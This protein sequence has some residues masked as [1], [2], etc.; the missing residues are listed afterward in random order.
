MSN[1][2]SGGGAGG[3]RKKG[4]AAAAPEHHGMTRPSWSWQLQ[5]GKSAAV[6]AAG[7]DPPFGSYIGVEGS[8][9]IH[10]DA[11][12]LDDALDRLALANRVGPVRLRSDSPAQLKWKGR[13]WLSYPGGGDL[14]Q[15]HRHWLS[16]RSS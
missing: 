11:P 6:V 4:P 9:L 3:Q 13:G 7:A 15:P 8:N 10:R 2:V 1:G 14:Q 16:G 5:E 12:G